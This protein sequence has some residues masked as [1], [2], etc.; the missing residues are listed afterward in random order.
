MSTQLRE[1]I[2]RRPDGIAV[3]ALMGEDACMPMV[4]EAEEAGIRLMYLNMP[5]ER[6]VAETGGGYVGSSPGPFGGRLGE[7]AVR[8]FGLGPGDKAICYSPWI[9]PRIEDD[10]MGNT[11]LALEEA[12][13]EV[14]RITIPVE[15]AADTSL[16]IPTFAA[17]LLA[18]PDAD[19]CFI[20]MMPQ[21][22][23]TL[24]QI[25]EA[26]GL[27]PG[28]ILFA[29]FDNSPAILEAF[30]SGYLHLSIDQQPFLQGYLP[31]MSLCLTLKYGL[32]PISMDTGSAFITQDNYAQVA[33]LVEAGLR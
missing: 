21:Y 11:A 22:A 1:A 16:A 25:Y 29:G 2:A 26:A 17:S 14:V 6:L 3:L 20:D 18:N 10:R 7:E 5:S 12:G 23:T 33:E 9:V 13:V 8:Q 4:R 32:S 24:P 31:V 15:W 28:D 19:I 30:E 27:E